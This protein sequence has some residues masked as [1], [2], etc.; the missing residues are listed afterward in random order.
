MLIS[1]ERLLSLSAVMA[2]LVVAGCLGTDETIGPTAISAQSS[3]SDVAATDGG[4]QPS[5]SE[6]AA[7]AAAIA[8][9]SVNS[10]A[11]TVQGWIDTFG[12][13]PLHNSPV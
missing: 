5:L 1:R 6:R 13:R 4:A 3:V 10:A 12:E 2:V 11:A 9:D 8:G 7:A